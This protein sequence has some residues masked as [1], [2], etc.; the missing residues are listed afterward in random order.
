MVKKI[1]FISHYSLIAV[2]VIL[3]VLSASCIAKTETP[4]AT[5]IPSTDVPAV[6]TAVPPSP[7]EQVDEPTVDPTEIPETTGP[8]YLNPD[9][10]IEERVDDLLARMPG[11]VRGSGG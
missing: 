3:M 6:E 1:N 9:L 11:G 8:A 10:P 5:A 2:I 7:T 4:E